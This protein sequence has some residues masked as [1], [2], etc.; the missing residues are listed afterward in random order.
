MAALTVLG[1]EIFV[2]TVY[3][4]GYGW[5]VVKLFIYESTVA[6]GTGNPPGQATAVA[7]AN[8]VI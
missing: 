1:Y 3:G 6:Y 7:K 2:E 5:F 8:H 4:C